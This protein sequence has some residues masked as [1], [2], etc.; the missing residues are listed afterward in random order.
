MDDGGQGVGNARLIGAELEALGQ[1]GNIGIR[2][3]A[4]G[5]GNALEVQDR[6]DLEGIGGPGLSCS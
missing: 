6:A 2:D 5:V 1:R 3:P 4:L